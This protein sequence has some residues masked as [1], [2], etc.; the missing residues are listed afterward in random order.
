MDGSTIFDKQVAVLIGKHLA[1]FG[2]REGER[3]KEI[4]EKELEKIRDL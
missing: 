3:S 1:E 4:D 2:E